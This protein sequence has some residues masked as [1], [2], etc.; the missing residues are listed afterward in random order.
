MGLLG[1]SPHTLH[2]QHRHACLMLAD[3]CSLVPIRF[4]DDP[5]PVHCCVAILKSRT[6][7]QLL[8]LKAAAT[9]S[10]APMHC[11]IKCCGSTKNGTHLC[12]NFCTMLQ[13]AAPSMRHGHLSKCVRA[14]CF[15]VHSL[16][17]EVEQAPAEHVLSEHWRIML[18]C[19]KVGLCV[20]V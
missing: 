5:H 18:A 15:P 4:Q 11:R 3:L 16:A 2:L 6:A 13:L 8:G 20:K 12:S 9:T 17:Q 7:K 10:T 14:D 1:L 19:S